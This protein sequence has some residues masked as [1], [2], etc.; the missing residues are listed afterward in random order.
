MGGGG[1]V[2]ATRLL[3]QIRRELSG[4]VRA[5]NSDEDASRALR[6]ISPAIA[7]VGLLTRIVVRLV[8]L[9]AGPVISVS[10]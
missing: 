7:P 4:R 1:W 3:T 6:P 2:T 5:P 9:A 8:L 10:A